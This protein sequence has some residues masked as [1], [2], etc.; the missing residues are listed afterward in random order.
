LRCQSPAGSGLY[1]RTEGAP[2]SCVSESADDACGA[3]AAAQSAFAR[4]DWPEG[5]TLRVRMGLHTGEAPL[6]GNEYI[7]LDVHHAARVASAAHGGEV[8]VS[9]TTRGLVEEH[10]P[11][12]QSLRDLGTHRLKDLARPERLYQ[13][14]IAGV[15]DQFPALR[16]L[17]ST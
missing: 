4:H 3:A 11:D 9:E 13:L 6:V 16:T 8:V 17:D 1:L 12:G 14:V 15:P 10:L 5:V 2:Y 7:G